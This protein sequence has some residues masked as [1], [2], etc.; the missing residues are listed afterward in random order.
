ML[1]S[2]MKIAINLAHS[3]HI[4]HD[5]KSYKV[6]IDGIVVSILFPS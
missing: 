6:V 1:H 5:D 3:T 4:A 2:G